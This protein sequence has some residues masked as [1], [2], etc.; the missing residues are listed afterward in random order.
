MAEREHTGASPGP[1]PQPEARNGGSKL[2][3]RSRDRGGLWMD[4][5]EAERAQSEFERQRRGD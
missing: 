4:P 1:R 2:E 3:P 5:D